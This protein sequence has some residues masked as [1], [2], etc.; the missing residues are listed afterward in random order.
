LLPH[1]GHLQT[2]EQARLITI[3]LQY[4]EKGVKWD[5]TDNCIQRKGN[6]NIKTLIRINYFGVLH[7]VPAHAVA[8]LVEELLYRLEDRGFSAQWTHWKILLT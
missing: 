5:G 4:W 6:A 3:F 8:Q 2:F 7:L 1:S